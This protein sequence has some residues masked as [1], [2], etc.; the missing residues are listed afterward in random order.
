MEQIKLDKINLAL[1][2]MDD[3]YWDTIADLISALEQEA[4]QVTEAI[5][6]T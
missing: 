6:D 2:L 4:H 5:A 3:A 1:S